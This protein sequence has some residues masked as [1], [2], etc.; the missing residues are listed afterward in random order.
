[1]AISAY[2]QSSEIHSLEEFRQKFSLTV[3]SGEISIMERVHNLVLAKHMTKEGEGRYREVWDPDYFYQ[4]KYYFVLSSSKYTEAKYVYSCDL[5]ERSIRCILAP[6]RNVHFFKNLL[7]NFSTGFQVP[8]DQN[9]GMLMRMGTGVVVVY[10]LTKEAGQRQV[11]K[12][13]VENGSGM[14]WEGSIDEE[15]EEIHAFD[16]V[17]GEI[18]KF[19]IFHKK[20]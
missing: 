13:L 2:A 3:E 17:R 10:D 14:G 6:M 19:P 12:I 20:V 1:M 11:N 18:R 4:G 5:K 8:G 9:P 15:K 7:I 16:Y